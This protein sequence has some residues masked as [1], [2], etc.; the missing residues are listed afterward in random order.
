[1]L[2]NRPRIA[3]E[4]RTNRAEIAAHKITIRYLYVDN[5]S[6]TTRNIKERVKTSGKFY[7]L[8]DSE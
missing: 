5:N 6:S 2:A 8:N 4:S 3:S 7:V 1:M